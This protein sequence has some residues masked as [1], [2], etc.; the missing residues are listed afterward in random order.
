M[1]YPGNVPIIIHK[2]IWL[3]ISQELNSV[4]SKTLLVFKPAVKLP[5][6]TI[7]LFTQTTN[8]VWHVGG[9]SKPKKHIPHS[10]QQISQ[11][12]HHH[13]VQ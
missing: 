1:F 13:S 3:N 9:N 7:Y 5:Q 10:L 8:N 4:G 12:P 11:E 6:M 2:T